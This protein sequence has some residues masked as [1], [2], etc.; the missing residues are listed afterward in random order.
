MKI[1]I[2]CIAGLFLVQC[3]VTTVR[4]DTPAYTPTRKMDASVDIQQW[5]VNA[6]EGKWDVT[7][8]FELTNTG[9]VQIAFYELYFDIVCEDGST[10]TG[11]GWG[12]YSSIADAYEGKLADPVLPGG[13]SRGMGGTSDCTSK[14]MS[15]TLRDKKLCQYR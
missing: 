2:L 5:L 14:P 1:L 9:N 15:V 10:Y 7:I 6:L 3:G 11:D 13:K 4:T 12:P 8:F